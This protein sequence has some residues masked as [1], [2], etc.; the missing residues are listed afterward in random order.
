MELA[1][2]AGEGPLSSAPF[3]PPHPPFPNL[4]LLAVLGFLALA[5]AYDLAEIN[6]LWAY[7]VKIVSLC[8]NP[9]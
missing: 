9:E 2:R 1:V 5:K 8:S 6:N 4:S 7:H 3:D